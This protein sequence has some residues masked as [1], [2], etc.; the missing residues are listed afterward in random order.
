VRVYGRHYATHR[1]R[2]ALSANGTARSRHAMWVLERRK[3]HTDQGNDGAG[4]AR[5]AAA[6]R[7]HCSS[8]VEMKSGCGSQ[9][10]LIEVLQSI[11][12]NVLC[13]EQV[14]A[15]SLLPLQSDRAWSAYWST[16]RSTVRAGHEITCFGEEIGIRPVS[17]PVRLLMRSESQRIRFTVVPCFGS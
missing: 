2:R 8:S 7:R 17:S 14:D 4:T 10:L 15:R 1:R 13:S 12:F 5:E 16:S 6:R 9:G 11:F 3:Q